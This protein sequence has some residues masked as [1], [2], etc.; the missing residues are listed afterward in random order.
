MLNFIEP[1]EKPDPKVILKR[2]GEDGVCLLTGSKLDVGYMPVDLDPSNVLPSNMVCISNDV[3]KDITYSYYYEVLFGPYKVLF[4]TP[5][6]FEKY[7]LELVKALPTT[8]LHYT[9]SLG[10]QNFVNAFEW[11]TARHLKGIFRV[12]YVNHSDVDYIF[13]RTQY[14]GH[15]FRALLKKQSASLIH[16]L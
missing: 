10:S 12:A 3:A 15:L 5:P 2:M 6:Q 9:P 4:D 13:D 14:Q 1:G 8:D 11:M 16:T 7:N